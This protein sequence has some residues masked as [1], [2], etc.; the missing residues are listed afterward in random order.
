[1]CTDVPQTKKKQRRNEKEIKRREK[2]RKKRLKH[3]STRKNR[4]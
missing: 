2:V 1:M 3:I 4:K